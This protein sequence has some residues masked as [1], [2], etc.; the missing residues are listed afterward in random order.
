MIPRCEWCGQPA[1][2]GNPTLCAEC[3]Y[4]HWYWEKHKGQT[5][6]PAAKD[7]TIMGST[8]I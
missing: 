4:K 2:K 7:K 6:E 3:Y 8:V 5:N 1:V